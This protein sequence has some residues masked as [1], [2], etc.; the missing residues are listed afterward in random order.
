MMNRPNILGRQIGLPGAQVLHTSPAPSL[1]WAR[2]HHPIE[3]CADAQSPDCGGWIEFRAPERW[4][5]RV[6]RKAID[7]GAR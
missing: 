6:V 1:H 3:A 7:C 4:R 5:A 2:A